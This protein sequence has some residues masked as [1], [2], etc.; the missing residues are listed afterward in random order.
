MSLRCATSSSRRQLTM[1]LQP[2]TGI[3]VGIQTARRELAGPS[4]EIAKVDR[5][6]NRAESEVDRLTALVTSLAN[7]SRITLGTIS[8]W[9]LKP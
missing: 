6:L 2:M 9:K 7:A 5:L 3:K 1:V 4:R 8:S